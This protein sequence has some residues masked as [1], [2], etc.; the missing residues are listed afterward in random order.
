MPLRSSPWLSAARSLSACADSVCWRSDVDG[1]LDV[2]TMSFVPVRPNLKARRIPQWTYAYRGVPGGSPLQRSNPPSHLMLP[3]SSRRT[4]SPVN[5]QS[6]ATTSDMA[7]RFTDR[8]RDRM[9]CPGQ[10]GPSADNVRGHFTG[11]QSEPT[12]APPALIEKKASP[13][14]TTDGLDDARSMDGCAIG[15]SLTDYVWGKLKPALSGVNSMRARGLQSGRTPWGVQ[16]GLGVRVKV[17][18]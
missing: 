4:S 14:L 13:R 1:S 17:Q 3:S 18:L 7:E 16:D 6:G 10:V 8:S 2:D 5:Q 11:T 9:E 15:C 12:R